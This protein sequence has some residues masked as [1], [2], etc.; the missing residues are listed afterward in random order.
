MAITKYTLRTPTYPPWR[1]FATVQNRL[2]GLFE[3]SAR[4]RSWAPSVNVF[5]TKDG[6][7]LT[8]E[9]PGLSQENVSIELENNVLTIS[10]EK[11]EPITEADVE[12]RFHVSERGYGAFRRAFTVPWTVDGEGI[13]ATFESGVLTVLLPKAAEAKGRTIEIAKN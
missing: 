11:T 4:A 2:A 5:E 9:L 10:G 7:T 13:V 12:Q 8:A 1:D 6:L 3:D